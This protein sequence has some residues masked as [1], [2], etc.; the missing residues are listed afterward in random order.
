[1]DVGKNPE[2]GKSRMR[3]VAYNQRDTRG[4]ALIERTTLRAMYTIVFAFLA[5]A[6]SNVSVQAQL[7]LRAGDVFVF[8]FDDLPLTGSSPNSFPPFSDFLFSLVP[9]SFQ[10]GTRLRYEMFADNTGEAPARSSV[11]AIEPAGEVGLQSLGT[12]D[13]RQG[14]I[15]LTVLKGALVVNAISI[16]VWRFLDDNTYSLYSTNFVP[17]PALWMDPLGGQQWKLSWT[18]NA[19]D[20]R[21]ESTADLSVPAWVPW[22]GP[23]SLEDSNYSTVVEVNDRARF[24]RLISNPS[25][26]VLSGSRGLGLGRLRALGFIPV[27]PT[28]TPPASA[29]IGWG[30]QKHESNDKRKNEADPGEGHHRESSDED[31]FLREIHR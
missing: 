16:G 7:L 12:W 3:E 1:M 22:K 11:L 15:R 24:F 14:A 27:N 2:F 4:R 8:T 19:V 20:F 21:V 23:V 30:L 10:P 18:T 13:D 25:S 31:L 28:Q 9:G 17:A 6:T 29:G 5:L 26:I